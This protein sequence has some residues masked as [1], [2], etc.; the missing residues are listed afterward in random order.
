MAK[1]II[2]NAETGLSVRTKLN[3]NFTELY[4]GKVT[5]SGVSAISVVSTAPSTTSADVLYIV[6][7]ANSTTA[8][9]VQLGNINLFSGNTGGNTGGV[10][11][12]ATITGLQLWL[13]AADSNTLY[14]STSG[15]S[16]VISDNATVA[17]WEDKSGNSRHAIQST[18]NAR[19]VLKTG[20]RN[21]KNALRFD[22]VNDFLDISSIQIPQP[23]TVFAAF[24]FRNNGSYLFDKTNA[25]NRVAIGWNASGTSQDNGK[26]FYFAGGTSVPADSQ[27]SAFTNLIITTL[28]NGQSSF[29]KKN[30]SQ[31]LSANS[32]TAP[33]DSIRFATSFGLSAPCNGDFYEILIYNSALSQSQIQS[34][35]TYL[36]TKWAIY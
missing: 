16:L 33:I 1:Q 21:F 27:S 3:S 29:L 9:A 14:D 13:D 35:E 12:P 26:I 6:V 34:V 18:A 25:S 22:G 19:P 7:P 2:N 24:I 23:Y 4:E 17:R 5:G 20:I 30:G 11:D 32:G 8:S 28:F 31:I 15:G 10:F 36:N